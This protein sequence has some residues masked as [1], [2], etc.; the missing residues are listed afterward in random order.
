MTMH[1]DPRDSHPSALPVR[2]DEPSRDSPPERRIDAGVASDLAAGQARLVVL[3][4]RRGAP[5]EAILVRDFDGA[6]HAYLNRC[7][8][9]PIPLDSGS[10]D[11]L[12]EAGCHL[13]CATHGAL[14][15]LHDGL[16]VDGPCEGES[17]DRL[18][19]GI[20]DGRVYLLV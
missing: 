16:C 9:L 5:R 7:K 2:S 4:A 17:L 11:F 8:H 12:D 14:Y 10:R 19:I 3:G 6:L 18:P 1:D 15:R 13:L 20:E